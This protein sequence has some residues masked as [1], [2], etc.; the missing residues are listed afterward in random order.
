MP[1]TF[2]I[3]THRLPTLTPSAFLTH[4]ETSHI[5]LIQSIAG[6]H[7]PISHTRRYIQRSVA[8]DN[9]YPATVLIGAPAEFDYDAIAELV[10]EDEAA[11][12]MFLGLIS[13]EDAARRIRDD[14][15]LFLDRSRMRVVVLGE[16]RVTLGEGGR[17]G[18]GGEGEGRE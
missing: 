1:Y 14:E 5:P 8:A 16:C 2:L 4:Y 6:F 18:G 9:D 7:F 3:F 12:R 17:E 13:E 10:F 11:Y 15:R